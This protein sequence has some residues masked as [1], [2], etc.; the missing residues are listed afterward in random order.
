MQ[1]V[2]NDLLQVLGH[3][4]PV[5]GV[6]L[7]REL[8]VEAED[9]DRDV[10]SGL[11]PEYHPCVRHLFDQGRRETVGKTILVM[12]RSC[13]ALSEFVNELHVDRIVADLLAG[14]KLVQIVL[15]EAAEAV[16]EGGVP[17]VATLELVP[18]PRGRALVLEGDVL[19]L[20]HLILLVEE[21]PGELLVLDVPVVQ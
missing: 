2:L 16:V 15:D 6:E 18:G 19:Y 7:Q 20:L 8:D 4:R 1:E 11:V 9:L 12:R 13:V 21:L 17:A 3:A 5:V 14:V 10:A